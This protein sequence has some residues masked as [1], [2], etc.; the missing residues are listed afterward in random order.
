MKRL[1]AFRGL[2][3]LIYVVSGLIF[4]VNCKHSTHTSFQEIKSRLHR[5]S[6]ISSTHTGLSGSW[7]AY[8]EDL[9]NKI[10]Q[11]I[12]H[13]LHLTWDKGDLIGIWLS[14]TTSNTASKRSSSFAHRHRVERKVL[15]GKIS[16]RAPHVT[17]YIINKKNQRDDTCMLRSQK[18]TLNMICN[19]KSYIFQRKSENTP[20]AYILDRKKFGGIWTWYHRSIDKDGDLKIEFEKWHLYQAG[21]I[22]KGFYQRRVRVFSADGRIFECSEEPFYEN[23]TEY[24]LLG[25]FEGKE[26]YLKEIGFRIDRGQCETGKR[27]L[28]RYVGQISR[29]GEQLTLR[30]PKGKQELRRRY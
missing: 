14:Y 21:K 12:S 10:A 22:L 9:K 16:K 30:W 27:R 28:D 19:S 11:K 13:E 15:I 8:D 25:L 20:I 26:I 17:T 3:T 6:D 4:L 18:D 24:Q 29:S 7:D 23:Q 5:Y 1:R 2:F